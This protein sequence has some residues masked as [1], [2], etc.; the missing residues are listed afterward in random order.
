MKNH[1]YYFTKK[2]LAGGIWSACLL[3]FPGYSQ[4][5]TVN[6][7]QPP[8]S[9]YL[10]EFGLSPRIFNLLVSPMFQE[11]LRM[12]GKWSLR[13]KSGTEEQ[14]STYGLQ[15]DPFYEYG[16][17]LRLLVDQ[18][19]GYAYLPKGKLKRTVGRIH[20]KYKKVK[21]TDLVKEGEVGLVSSTES[22]TILIF[23][24]R[25]SNLPNYLNY[26]SHC[27]GR[28]Y[29]VAGQLDRIELVLPEP[30][31]IKGTEAT[32]YSNILTFRKP[33][34][35]GY[36]LE[37]SEERLKGSRKGQPYSFTNRLEINSYQNA[38]GQFVQGFG[39]EPSPS[40]AQGTD[41]I[42]VKLERSFPFL[43]NA[44]RKA[45]YELP[46]PYGVNV[47][48]HYQ[49]ETLGLEK[50]ILNGEDLT[51]A[52]LAPGA[53]SANTITT[54]WAGQADLWLLP[55]VNVMVMGGYIFGNTDVNLQLSEEVKEI[56]G[57]LDV[58]AD[59]ISISSDIKGPMLGA[60]LTLAGGYKNFFATVNAMYINQFVEE[61]GISVNAVAITP[62]A[63]IR[64]PRVINVLAGGQYQIY[65]SKVSGNITLEKETVSFSVD[66]KAT[67][68]NWVVGVQRDFPITGT[69][70]L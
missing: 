19:S 54:L 46:L 2:I 18:D 11:E 48:N 21:G 58:Q 20:E 33:E 32:S 28:V 49:R 45:G 15:Y 67:E 59:A 70:A 14:K 9:S 63:G 25:K 6:Y 3:S 60:G 55:F 35:A 64:F 17:T 47:F 38:E 52:L 36:L 42:R 24:L 41:T 57:L 65:D 7:Q 13:E 12:E 27:E 31:T 61:A 68:W 44:A 5:Q 39:P 37:A 56:L 51:Q 26:L 53:S 23:R 69:E 22:E 8:N 43:G 1:F 4:G 30:R 10:A 62:L 50:V 40:P 29:L 16:L 34:G 66:L